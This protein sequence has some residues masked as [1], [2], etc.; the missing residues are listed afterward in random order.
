MGAGLA[1][2]EDFQLTEAA[3]SFTPLER[4]NIRFIRHS[5]ASVRVTAAHARPS[6]RP[7]QTP[8][9]P[10]PKVKASSQAAGAPI[11]Q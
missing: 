9:A 7:H 8:T 5:N 2:D 1:G 6:A 4:P 3:A 10:M 11:T